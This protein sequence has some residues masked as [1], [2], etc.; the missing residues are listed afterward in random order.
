MRF[1]ATVKGGTGQEQFPI[2]VRPEQTVGEVRQ[3]LAA[4][5]ME[6][7]GLDPVSVQPQ[8]TSSTTTATTTLPRVGGF[9]PADVAQI[10]GGGIGTLAGGPAVGAPAALAAR[11]AI[12]ALNRPESPGIG[13]APGTRLAQRMEG[14]DRIGRGI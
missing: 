4:Q 11:F 2:E 9:S 14:Q 13:A 12:G 3:K 7:V 6:L 5:G 10:A 1:T 8:P